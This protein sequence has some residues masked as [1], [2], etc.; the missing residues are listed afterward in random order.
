MSDVWS[1]IFT[2]APTRALA[3]GAVLFRRDDPIH[4]AYLLLEGSVR[5]ERHLSDGTRLI[6]DRT[7]APGL[8]ARASLFV[9]R[10]HCDALCETSCRVAVL[11]RDTTLGALGEADLALAAL[12]DTAKDVQALRARLEVM[13]LK[14]VALR[15]DAYLDLH[16]VPAR[17]GWVAVADWIGVTPPALYREL[18]KRRAAGE[19]L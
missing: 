9:K 4:S 6:I 11:P 18:S 2:S 1:R 19:D 16:G 3:S 13:R 14:S 7:V 15:L 5:L 8:V 12:A 10:Y 17:G